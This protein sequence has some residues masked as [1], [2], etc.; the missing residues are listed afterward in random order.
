MN[1]VAILLSIISA[2]LFFV[3]LKRPNRII[4]LYTITRP[5][6]QPFVF[7]NYKLLF[8]PYSSLWA[9]I[10]PS[11]LLFNYLR[12][13]WR[14]LFYNSLT[15]LLLV[16]FA[17]LSMPFS[18]DLHASVEG[19]LKFLVVYSALIIS[20]NSV[21]SSE[22]ADKIINFIILSSIVPL[23]FGFYQA[24][25]GEYD[26]IYSHVGS[27]DR[28]NSLFGVGNAY[29]IYLSI[30]MCATLIMLLRKDIS[31]NARAFYFIIISLMA[32]SQ[33]LALNRGTWIALSVAMI[34]SIVKYLKKI[35]IRWFIIGGLII[36]LAFSNTIYTRFTD[37]GQKWTGEEKDTFQ[38]RIDGWLYLLPLIAKRPILGHGVGTTGQTVEINGILQPHNDYVTIAMDIGIPGVILYILF[39]A[40]L[41]IFFLKRSN[42]RFKMLVHYNFPMTILTTYIIIISMTQNIVY[43]MINFVLFLFLNGAIIKL[44]YLHL[45]STSKLAETQ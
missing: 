24:F 8:I 44:N 18:I 15:L 16:L 33:I 6:I 4:G 11:A 38:D 37:E 31:K 5:L 22:D 28:V 42:I 32:I 35:R 1:L 21:K 25:I 39:L 43:N 45:N 40:S 26:Q 10:L 20:Y 41:A 30:T 17:V 23:I 12:N 19:L 29:G 13:G 14:L 27:V 34:F 9:I 3:L 2:I 36:L 7:L